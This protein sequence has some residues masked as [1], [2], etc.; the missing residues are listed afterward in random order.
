MSDNVE[1]QKRFLKLVVARHLVDKETAQDVWKAADQTSTSVDTVLMDRG[2]LNQHVVDQLMDDVEKSFG[3]KTIGGFRIIAEL[4]KGGMGAVYKAVQESIDREVALKVMAPHFAKNKQAGDRFIREA[5]TA[6]KVNHPNV[7]SIIDVGQENGQYYMALELVSGGDAEQLCAQEG[8]QLSEKRALEIIKDAS[9]GLQAIHQVGLV[10]RDIKPA[11]IFISD[12]GTAKLADLGLARSEAGEDKMTQTGATVGTPAFMSPEQAEGV[13]DLDIRSDIY[14][15]GATLYALVC[16]VPPYTGNSA[17]A[18]VAKAINDPV[19]DASMINNTL[20][21]SCLKLINDCMNKDRDERIQTPDELLE[22]IDHAITNPSPVAKKS[23]SP[24]KARK[25]NN[26]EAAA[27]SKSPNKLTKRLAITAMV[28]ILLALMIAGD[29]EN[30]N[31]SN[32]LNNSHAMNNEQIDNNGSGSPADT[33]VEPTTPVDTTD[34]KPPT[35]EPKL[36]IFQSGEIYLTQLNEQV[37]FKLEQTADIPLER[38]R[39]WTFGKGMFGLPNAGGEPIRVDGKVYPNGL[40]MHPP[41]DNSRASIAY[42]VPKRVRRISGAVG[43]ND[44]SGRGSFKGELYFVILTPAKKDEV[45]KSKPITDQNRFQR[46]DV[47][48]PLGT[49]RLVLDVR[50]VGS[51]HYGQG[52]W[53][54]PKLSR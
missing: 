8:G 53:L 25:R 29:D 41:G 20:S 4:G 38:Y 36:P 44:T 7:I 34:N 32:D 9:K 54:D 10:H 17:W 37:F 26:P 40:A 51:Y 18:V 31:E 50:C 15:L 42:N 27:E 39:K 24:A 28:F 16:G 3:P 45:W 46:F 30:P 14:A 23:K 35:R 19:P 11:N 33:N 1:K 47:R 43:L 6:G 22:K 5:K 2:L 21:G 49:R 12:D 52:A 13:E 48:L